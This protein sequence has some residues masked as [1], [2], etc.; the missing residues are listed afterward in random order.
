M[1]DKDKEYRESVKHYV[2]SIDSAIHYLTCDY[3]DYYKHQS[4]YRHTWL[5]LMGLMETWD[6][7]Q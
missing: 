1:T 6:I 7:T 4:G 2:N 3:Y 5:H